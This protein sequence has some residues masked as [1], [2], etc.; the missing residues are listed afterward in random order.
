LG[1]GAAVTALACVVALTPSGTA[2]AHGTQTIPD[3]AYYRTEITAVQ[4]S[5]VGVTAQVDPAGEWIQLTSVSTTEIII[6]GYT[7]EPYLRMKAGVVEEN[8]ISPSTFLNRSLFTDS[9]PTEAD[10]TNLPPVWRQIGTNGVARWHDHRIHWMG[11]VLPPQVQADP[12]H[13]H[14][15]GDWVVHATAAGVPFE[16]RGSLRWI[17]KPRTGSLPP[18]WLWAVEILGTAAIALGVVARV[19]SERR[20][21]ATL[22]QPNTPPQGFPRDDQ[23]TH[24]R[25]R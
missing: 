9:L 24:G 16:I 8:Q 2:E 1:G 15:V 17:G 14:P 6:L 23:T 25:M 20:A 21:A 11:G 13:A 4:P 3:A 12:S 18:I 7:K 10:S 22:A 19:R 5:P